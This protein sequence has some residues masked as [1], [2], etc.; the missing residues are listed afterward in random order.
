M[1]SA[2][3][4]SIWKITTNAYPLELQR[5]LIVWFGVEGHFDDKKHPL[6]TFDPKAYEI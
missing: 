6:A 1:V 5:K 2:A 3:T 4:G